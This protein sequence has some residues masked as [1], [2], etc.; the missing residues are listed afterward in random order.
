MKIQALFLSL[1]ALT[2]AAMAQSSNVPA[3]ISYS[4]KVVDASGNAITGQR[5]M[6]FRVWN[7]PTDAASS[8]R[9]WSEQQTVVLSAGEFSVLI[10]AGS[11]VA[12]ETNAGVFA[13]VFG[14][15]TRYLGVTVDDGTSA[16]DPEISPRQQVVTT[17]FAF[18]ARVAETVAPG[19]VTSST[20]G[21]AAVNEAA[22]ATAAVTAAKLAD[23]SVQTAKIADGS[24]TT[25]KIADG[26]VTSAKLASGQIG[27]N[28]LTDGSLGTSKLADNSVTSAKI[29]DGS[30]ALVDLAANSV[31]ASKLTDGAVTL[32]KHA[33]NSVNAAKIVDAAISSAKLADLAVIT[34]K[35]ADGAVTTAKLGANSV[36]IQKLANDAVDRSKLHP[37]VRAAIR[38]APEIYDQAVR[39]NYETNTSGTYNQLVPIDIENL[40]ND[41]D[42]CRILI[43][44]KHRT[45][46]NDLSGWSDEWDVTEIRIHLTQRGMLSN[47]DF[48][49]SQ[50]IPGHAVWYQGNGTRNDYFWLGITDL[51]THWP[52]LH[53]LGG[54]HRDWYYLYTYY[55][56]NQSPG[57]ASPWNVRQPN[58]ASNVNNGGPP[59][60]MN[61]NSISAENGVVT[62]VTRTGHAIQAGNTVTISGVAGAGSA[63]LPD[64]NG[65]RV[66]T[67]VPSRNSFQFN[68][69]NANG[70]Y[71]GGWSPELDSAGFERL[72][73]AGY[74]LEPGAAVRYQ[75]TYSKFRLWMIVHQHTS[76]R[77]IVYDN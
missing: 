66:V 55:P 24:V 3:L 42:G 53:E 23:L 68:L 40:G 2:S 8:N 74:K 50:Y 59:V 30:V 67:A 28:V 20:L 38:R 52:G 46:S 7:H 16:P 12:G 29:A 58:N 31:D 6:I 69:T 11:A 21:A 26:A 54:G 65:G 45:Q 44:G 25:A 1:L 18:R 75:P 9:I 71:S 64:P 77:V 60:D 10:G 41:A 17:A 32:T 22:L 37:T 63:S 76:A 62:V 15:S 61:I 70:T 48:T 57:L 72:P 51:S 5:L 13:D 36:T 34:A 35:L 56:G 47:G 4:G 39:P 33:D 19:A 73:L 49:S 14:G 27:A 43:I